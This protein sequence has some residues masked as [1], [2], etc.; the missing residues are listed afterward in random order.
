MT[1]DYWDDYGLLE[2]TGMTTDE[3]GW[4]RKLEMTRDDWDDYGWLRMIKDDKGWLD[5][6]KMT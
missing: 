5:I 2:M 6:T 4:L 1:R 3:Y